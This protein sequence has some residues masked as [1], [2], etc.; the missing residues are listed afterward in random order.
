[1]DI[2]K[3]NTPELKP[4]ERFRLSFPLK[5]D[6]YGELK[7]KFPGLPFIIINKENE[8]IWGLDSYGFLVSRGIA[9]TSVM[10][11]DISEKDGLILN[12][13]LKEKWTGTNLYEKLVFIEKLLPLAEKKDIYSQT[14]LDIAI[15]RNL[16]E[17]LEMLLQEEFYTVL[18]GQRVTLKTAL[19]LC[20][21]DSDDRKVLLELFETLS[22]SS[23]HQL[24]ILEMAEE[25][26]FRDKC[27]LPE[28]FRKTGIPAFIAPES[29]MEKPQ[30]T[31]IDALFKYR[32]PAYNQMETEWQEQIKRLNLPA[33]VRVSHYPFFEKKQ[34]DV[35]VT[36]KDISQ[37]EALVNKIKSH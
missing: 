5:T 36:L 27:G 14:N 22:F 4:A 28:I 3:I 8:I 12:F 9:E 17:H 10:M 29:G 7:E 21:L 18:T 1:M 24:K 6:V 2:L 15:N 30:K 26:I 13:N 23:S 20:A 34:L 31:I 37:I 33:N 25:L 16:E 19:G 32:N 11:A 35:T